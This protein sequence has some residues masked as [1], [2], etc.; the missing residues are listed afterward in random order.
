NLHP[1]VLYDIGLLSAIRSIC[2]E[3]QAVREGI[4]IQT[5]LEIREEEV[6]K[7]LGIVIY[8]IL[9]E[10]LNNA[11]KHSGADTVD[12][13]LTGL[14]GFLELCIRDNGQGFDTKD[15]PAQGNQGKRIGLI[16]MK[17]RAEL[18]NGTF[19]I[20]SKEGGGTTILVRWA[21]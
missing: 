6:E 10:A 4:R 11:L 13:R 7:S 9:Q 16:S 19:E 1:S 21:Y 17:E 12:V 2:R 15:H 5:R 14:D 8:R 18:S 3:V 20:Q